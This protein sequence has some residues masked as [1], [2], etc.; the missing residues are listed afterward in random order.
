MGTHLSAAAPGRRPNALQAGATPEPQPDA[1][2]VM[3]AIRS[4][5]QLLRLSSRA[6]EKLVGL[7]G[8]QLFVL[9]QLKQGPA[10]SIAELARRTLTH[11]S[12][13]SVVVTRLAERG[14]VSRRT[15]Q[16]DARRTEIALT[17][18]GRAL[19]R[20]A[21]RTAQ[22]QL[23]EAVDRLEPVDRRLLA[24]G[25]ATLARDAGASVEAP[26]LFFEDK[27]EDKLEDKPPPEGT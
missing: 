8:A 22:A 23:L 15:S 3:D 21:P 11:Q 17:A 5:V 16:Q 18:A 20:R 12:S 7:S 13:V 14:L 4:I 24:R 26:P 25:L 27:L 6:C 19:V 2:I 10:A 1:R 9:Q